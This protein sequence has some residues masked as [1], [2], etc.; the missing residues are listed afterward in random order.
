MI[1]CV[2]LYHGK[3]RERMKHPTPMPLKVAAK[4]NN[5]CGT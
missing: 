4:E 5:N 2:S 3:G 1:K